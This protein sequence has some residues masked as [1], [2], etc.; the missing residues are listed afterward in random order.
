MIKKSKPAD[1]ERR[2]VDQ[3]VR[4]AIVGGGC[5]ALTTAFELTR[6][7]KNGPKFDVTVYQLGWRLGGKGASGRGAANRIEEHGLHV[8]LGFYENAFRLMRDCYQELDRD[9]EQCPVADWRDAFFPDRFVGLADRDSDGQW[10]HWT[11]WFPPAD[12]LPGDPFSTDNPFTMKGY[13]RRLVN[14]IRT[15]LTSVDTHHEWIAVN[16]PGLEPSGESRSTDT[17]AVD[18]LLRLVK[19]ALEYGAIGA[20][21]TLV[22]VLARFEVLLD[23]I[24]NGSYSP[25]PDVVNLARNITDAIR[26]ALESV[27]R[28]SDETRYIWEIIDLV[29]AIFWGIFNPKYRELWDPAKGFDAINDYECREWLIDNGASPTA[30]KSAFVRGLYDLAMAY[31]GGNPETPSL[32]AGQAIRGSLRMFFTYRGALFWKMSAGMGDIVFAPLYEVLKK[33]GVAFEFFHRLES[34]HL[35]EPADLAPGESRYV[36]SLTFDVQ[37]RTDEP[38]YA[39]LIDVDGLPCWPAEPDYDQLVDGD[40]MRTEGWQFESF[41]DRN[42]IG[43]KT[44]HVVEDFD[45]VVLGVGIGAIPY[46]C[47][48]I[49]ESDERWRAMVEHVQSVPTQAFQVWLNEDMDEL[50]WP[51]GPVNLSA[52]VKPFDTWADMTHLAQ[53]ET[54]PQAPKAIAYFCNV[55]S[56]PELPPDR[57]EADYP[58]RRHA[59]VRRHAV[60]FLDTDIRHLWPNAV[61]GDNGFRWDVLAAPEAAGDGEARFDTQF[62]TANVNPSDRYTL[63][64]AGSI[65]YRISPLDNTYDNLTIVGDWTDCGFTEGCVEAAVMSGKLGAHALANVPTL[66]EIIGYDHP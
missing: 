4:V 48:E 1:L 50:G 31:P 40:R 3:P 12:G 34:V 44:L 52:F 54:W 59:E 51:H 13:V 43:S 61:D 49:V 46:L 42:K 20:A 25:F 32:A 41:W 56:D 65:Q 64:P 38:E 55:L 53:R 11:T 58:A 21:A 5:A 23:S 6:P 9:P 17:P 57:S 26:N 37:A 62:W 36:K 10:L 47:E 24:P 63:A 28:K 39:P 66:D 27:I 14:L 35:A 29:L 45:F 16:K 30:A 8:W 18:S 15:L 33:R 60:Q 2:G 19:R 7:G 22:E